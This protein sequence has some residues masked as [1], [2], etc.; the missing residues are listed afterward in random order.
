LEGQ[1]RTYASTLDLLVTIHSFTPVFH[2]QPRSVELGL[3]HGRDARFCEA[4][5]A[6]LPT[7]RPYDTRINEPYSAADG[8]AHT[9]DLHGC[10]NGLWN[11]MIEI[12]NDLIQTADQQAA[13][14]AYLVELITATLHTLRETRGAS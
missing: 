1:V 8:V 14:A 10:D 7:G 6:H 2:G 11:V 9:L 12:R 4:M 3:L 13:M 5:M